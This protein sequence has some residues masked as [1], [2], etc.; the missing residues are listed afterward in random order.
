LPRILIFDG[1]PA[2]MQA[3]VVALGGRL[4]AELFANA[5]SLHRPDLSFVTVN[6]A[7][8]ESLPPGMT[9]DDLDGV[10]ITGSPLNVYAGGIEVTRQLDLARCLFEAGVPTYGSCWG[11]QVMCAA[12][13]GS[14]RLNPR[15]R[16]FGVA[17]AIRLTPAGRAHSL[18]DGKPDQFD[19]LC[20]HQD[21]VETLP[22]GAIVLATNAI[23]DIQGVEIRRARGSFVGVQYHPEYTFAGC[24]AILDLR[25]DRL[26]GEG[27]G[28]SPEQLAAIAAD[29][30]AL[31]DAA[32]RRDL[33]WR[34]G[35]DNMVLDPALRSRELGNWLD[36][37]VVPRAAARV[38]AA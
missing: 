11:M 9:I 17:R 6:V 37:A 26:V 7:D 2:S 22:D 32:P 13:G 5:L 16:E 24:A 1:A 36:A 19:A 25:V 29:W 15:G 14:V 38:A 20:S 21:E 23:S 4:N 35:L 28:T 31:E 8:G 30:R 27:F 18:F 33:A 34:Y 10:V 3:A 12:L